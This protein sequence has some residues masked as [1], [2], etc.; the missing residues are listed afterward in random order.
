MITNVGNNVTDIVT[1]DIIRGIQSDKELNSYIWSKL[2][3]V[4]TLKGFVLGISK[5][6]SNTDKSIEVISKKL[7]I[8]TS[9]I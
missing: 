2:E 8:K 9:P 4:K 6:P 3:E 5:I 1:E 7:V